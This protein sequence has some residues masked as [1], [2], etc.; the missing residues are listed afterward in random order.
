MSQLDS[1]DWSRLETCDMCGEDL[2]H[3]FVHWNGAFHQCEQCAV[4]EAL[5]PDQ[6]GRDPL[7]GGTFRQGMGPIYRPRRGL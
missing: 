3:D 6:N 2:P 4:L 5:D 1:C 7:V